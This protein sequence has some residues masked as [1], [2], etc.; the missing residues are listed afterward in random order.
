M[1]KLRKIPSNRATEFSKDLLRALTGHKKRLRKKFGG[2]VWRKNWPIRGGETIDVVGLSQDG[3]VVLIEAEL[4]REDPSSNVIKI[5]KWAHETGLK[6]RVLFVQSFT[7]PYRGRKR[8][9]LNRARFVAARMN[10]EFPNISYKA[11][12][13]AYNPR[14]GGKVGAGRR[15][16][17]A[18]NLGF[19]VIRLWNSFQKKNLY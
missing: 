2:L 8:E 13:L 3:P 12:R 11:V 4:L 17:Q 14:P 18:R 6:R 5:W 19:S 9:R 1:G 7:K 15:R 10:G 16:H